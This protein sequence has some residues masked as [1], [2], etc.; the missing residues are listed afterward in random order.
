ML[1]N[2]FRLRLN[3]LSRSSSQFRHWLL[4]LITIKSE[5]VL[6]DYLCLSGWH[7]W[8][9]MM[10]YLH[11]IGNI[12]CVLGWRPW[13]Y[14]QTFGKLIMLAKVF[15]VI[16]SIS[17][18]CSVC[19]RVRANKERPAAWKKWAKVSEWKKGSI[20]LCLRRRKLMWEAAL[21]PIWI[22]YVFLGIELV[23]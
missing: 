20:V 10:M 14:T 4:S 22:N 15:T 2:D 12:S 21:S 9:K 7:I 13:K 18:S 19:C 16:I 8:L 5:R 23:V 3:L 17:R 1:K 6:L 11:T